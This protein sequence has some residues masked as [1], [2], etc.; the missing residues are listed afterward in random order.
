MPTKKLSNKNTKLRGKTKDG[1]TEIKITF[2]EM[3]K[4]Y[5]VL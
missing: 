3:T 1:V 5:I 4:A 2:L